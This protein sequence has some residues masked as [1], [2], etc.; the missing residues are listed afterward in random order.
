MTSPSARQL[1]LLLVSPPAV[2]CRRR[3]RR[4]CHCWRARIPRTADWIVRAAQ[5]RASRSCDGHSRGAEDEDGRR[6]AAAAAACRPWLSRRECLVPGRARGV[7]TL[8]IS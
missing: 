4:R 1:A 5:R 6:A 7:F 2:W 8:D 3:R